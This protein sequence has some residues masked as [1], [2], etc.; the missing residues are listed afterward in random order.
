MPERINEFKEKMEEY[1]NYLE[2]ETCLLV[3]KWDIINQNLV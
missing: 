1:N 2:N 3:Q